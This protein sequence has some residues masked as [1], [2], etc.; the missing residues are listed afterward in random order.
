MKRI[1][2]LLTLLLALPLQAKLPLGEAALTEEALYM[3]FLRAALTEPENSVQ[4]CQYYEQALSRAPQSKYLRRIMLVCALERGDM[5]AADSYASYI[6]EGKNDAEDLSVY[7][8]YR[9][10]KGDLKEAQTYYEQALDLSPDDARILYQYVLLLGFVD[11]DLAAEKLQARKASYPSLAHVIDYETGNIYR[12]KKDAQNALYYYNLATKAN[13]SYAEPY[14][15][16]ADMYEKSSQFFLML[17]ELEELEKTGYE[18]AVMYSRMGSLFV[19]VKDHGRAKDYFQRAKTLDAGDIPAGYFLA[20]YAEEDG[21]FA[22][23]AQYLRETADYQQDSG[24]WIQTAFY[25]QRAGDNKAALDTLKEAYKKF[26]KNVEVGYFYALALHDDKKYRAA[27]RVFKG[28]LKTNPQYENARLAYAFNL[29]SMR[30][31]KEM[32]AQLQYVLTQNPNNAAAYNLLGFS[33]ADRN[34]RLEEAQELIIKALSLA[35]NDRAFADSLAWVY[36]RQGK[37][38]EAL[39]ILQSLDADFIAQNEDVSYHLGAVYAAL[40]QT[41]LARQYL[42]SVSGGIK[43]AAKLLKKLPKRSL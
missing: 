19:I 27:T 17:H 9:W 40:G 2:I 30:K 8:F 13:P 15:A 32:E 33:L 24:K 36:Y 16:R 20:L 4:S 26:E 3:D 21:K 43:A 7:A 18:S 12:S 42:T 34:L 31:Y 38:E 22:E 39:H 14:L 29:E 23:A 11:V 35:P 25:Q 28:L 6:Q 5:A 37:Y 10:R 41:E 1:F